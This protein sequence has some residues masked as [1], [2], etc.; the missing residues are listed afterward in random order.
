M[1]PL[2]FHDVSRSVDHPSPV[3]PTIYRML[4]VL[5]FVLFLKRSGVTVITF[6]TLGT[7]VKTDKFYDRGMV[8]ETGKDPRTTFEPWVVSG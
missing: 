3:F 4:H 8:V 6:P 2:L 5:W 7:K 1:L